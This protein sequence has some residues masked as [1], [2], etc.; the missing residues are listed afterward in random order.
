MEC[1]LERSL[2]DLS[3]RGPGELACALEATTT[4]L[5]EGSFKSARYVRDTERIHDSG[6]TA[7]DLRKRTAVA[8]QERRTT[9][10]R[11]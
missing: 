5:L 1:L 6:C 2:S 3:R 10:E 9:R 8:Y 4:P 11:L 7:R